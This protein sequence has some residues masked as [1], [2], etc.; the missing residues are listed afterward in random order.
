[1]AVFLFQLHRPPFASC[2]LFEQYH[3]ETEN[4]VQVFYRNSTETN[5]SA[6]EI[7]NCGAKCPLNKWYEV[8]KSILPTQ[9]F[10]EECELRDGQLLPASGNPESITHWYLIKSCYICSLEWHF[11][12]TDSYRRPRMETHNV[13][14]SVGVNKGIWFSERIFKPNGQ[15]TQHS[16]SSFVVP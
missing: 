11:I 12:K 14:F 10:E 5:I 6:L 13:W 9:T 4:Y 3:T 7:P 2:L 1:M 16:T 15:F 8:Y